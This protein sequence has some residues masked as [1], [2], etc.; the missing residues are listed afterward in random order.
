MA[1]IRLSEEVN[2]EDIEEALSLMDESQRSVI[3]TSP[4]LVIKANRKDPVSQIYQMLLKE[5]KEN[6]EHKVEYSEFE[7]KVKSCLTLGSPKGS[8]RFRVGQVCRPIR[9]VEYYYDRK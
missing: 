1:K 9:A 6:S 7:K 2:K 8:C 3:D 4:E 5:L